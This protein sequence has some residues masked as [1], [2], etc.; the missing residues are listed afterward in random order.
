MDQNE[1]SIQNQNII[2]NLHKWY[3]DRLEDHEQRL[4]KVELAQA[5]QTAYM[6]A[7]AAIGSMLGS[8]LI[9]GFL[10]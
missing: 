1:L 6:S 2:T 9:K 3:A 8:L 7:A 5:R 4:R 10:H